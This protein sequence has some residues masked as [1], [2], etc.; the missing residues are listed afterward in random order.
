MTRIPPL[1]LVQENQPV[2]DLVA[3]DPVQLKPQASD[4]QVVFVSLL[5]HRHAAVVAEARV[6]VPLVLP[7]EDLPDTV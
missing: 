3:V 2:P 6:G 4:I 1:V 7:L 5:G